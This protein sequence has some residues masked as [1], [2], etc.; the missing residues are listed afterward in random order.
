MFTMF[1]FYGNIYSKWADFKRNPDEKLKETEIFKN[2][3]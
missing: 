1:V 2:F 3:L